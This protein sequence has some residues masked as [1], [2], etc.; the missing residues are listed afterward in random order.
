[1]SDY[2]DFD[3]FARCNH[4][5]QI[6][7][8]LGHGPGCAMRPSVL[9]DVDGVCADFVEA[10]RVAL[11]GMWFLSDVPTWDFSTVP[12]FDSEEA[13]RVWRQEGFCASIPPYR[14]AFEGVADLMQIAD[15]TFVTS[16][17]LSSP[18][19]MFERAEWLALHFP[20]APVIFA[21][22]KSPIHGDYLIDDRTKHL[23]AW[24]WGEAIC[25]DAPYNR[26]WMGRRAHGWS[27][28][29][30]YIKRRMG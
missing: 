20:P 1:M 12:G 29:L 8:E 4:A 3:P 6:D 30:G 7:R 18:H 24:R 17:M 27:D 13:H 15:V 11:G 28:L 25:W 9:L 16:P 22:D 21:K 14:G 19:W 5:I 2:S 10:T 23:R 26:D